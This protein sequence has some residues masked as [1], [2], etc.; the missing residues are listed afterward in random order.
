[1]DAGD[2]TG[3][4]DPLVICR[5][6]EGL[7]VLDRILA[8]SDGV[9]VASDDAFVLGTAKCRP[10]VRKVIFIEGMESLFSVA[11]E[12][13]A[14]IAVIDGRLAATF[15]SLPRDV[16]EFGLH[17]EGGSTSQRV[18]DLCLLVDSYL[19]LIGDSPG[20]TIHLIGGEG[21]EWED[22]VLGACARARGARVTR[23]P[24]DALARFRSRIGRWL[25]PWAIA[26]YTL[27]AEQWMR[28]TGTRLRP[29]ASW[30][31]A[32]WFQICGSASRHVAN[33]TPIMRSIESKG[34][35]AV[36]VSWVAAERL[37]SPNATTLIRDQGLS[38]IR[39]EGYCT[40]SSS[41]RSVVLLL[42]GLRSTRLLEGMSYRGVPVARLMRES[43]RHHLVANVPQ[44]YRYDRAIG[45]LLARARPVAVKSWGGGDL[46]E[47]KAL[48][49]RLREAASP[50]ACLHFFYWVGTGYPWP[51]AD[52]EFRPELFLAKSPDECRLAAVQ[53]GLSLDCT[54]VTGSPRFNDY[55]VF[56]DTHDAQASR[57]LLG[58]PE[59]FVRYV[60]FDLSGH[61]RGF[62]SQR[63]Q[64]ELLQSMLAVADAHPDTMVVVKHHPG[65]PVTKVRHLLDEP[66]RKNVVLLP[67]V[68]SAAHFLNGVDLL[69]T[70]FST[71]MLEAS[72]LGKPVVSILLDREDNF[73]ILGD[74]PE[75]FQSTREFAVFME[76]ILRSPD[77]FESW[78]SE[79]LRMLKE[80]LPQYYARAKEESSDIAASAVLDW[81]RRKA[82]G[83][84]LPGS[85]GGDAVIGGGGS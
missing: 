9:V 15:P 28:L 6:R 76:R 21:H 55:P 10:G 3:V 83:Q 43:V 78:R 77:E 7:G 68:S 41:L 44:R 40:A 69:V 20:R 45:S 4:I 34:G 65:F 46:P 42:R 13:K 5:S 33:I 12:V 23:H 70:K 50:T 48:L 56:A 71:L 24:R 52:R 26:G 31:G 54:V 14:L 63:E 60:G 22:E 1:M 57:V 37:R 74:I 84:G 25:R 38:V 53:Y 82:K 51:Y 62:L 72:L 58:V 29:Q 81:C 59:G 30:D 11:E 66:V 49:R 27:C 32:V 80:R 75:T 16:V 61:L 8:R 36:A 85:A 73:R 79:R 39:L 47:G 18:Q 17:V 2:A 35:S 67:R 64:F 19:A